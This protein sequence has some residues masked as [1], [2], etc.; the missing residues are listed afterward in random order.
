[1]SSG[2]VHAPYCDTK[3]M[4]AEKSPMA[5][6]VYA[7]FSRFQSQIAGWHAISEGAFHQHVAL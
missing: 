2:R 3:P 7:S 5:K 6:K 4:L 1:M